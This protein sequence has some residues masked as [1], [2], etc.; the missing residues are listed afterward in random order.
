[1]RGY[2]HWLKARAKRL[3][4]GEAIRTREWEASTGK[5]LLVDLGTRARVLSALLAELVVVGQDGSDSQE[6][7]TPGLPHWGP[8]FLLIVR[9]EDGGLTVGLTIQG[10][11]C[12]V[13]LSLR[14]RAFLV[15]PEVVPRLAASLG[16]S[17]PSAAAI[18][19]QAFARD[20]LV[21]NRE[22]S[23]ILSALPE[24]EGE[25]GTGGVARFRACR[26]PATSPMDSPRAGP[27]L[28]RPGSPKPSLKPAAAYRPEVPVLAEEPAGVGGLKVGFGPVSCG[29]VS[30]T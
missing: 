18:L 29:A 22:V 16:G 20:V 19:C 25:L 4:P 10:D 28:H 8:A 1:M 5:D 15:E 12:E 3:T 17:D 6:T 21:G 13:R 26:F 2:F 7:Q 30:F 9:E 11:L 23:R 27:A 24:L 14:L